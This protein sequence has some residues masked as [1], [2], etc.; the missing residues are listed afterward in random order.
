MPLKQNKGGLSILQTIILAIF[1]VV[2]LSN[3]FQVDFQAEL[4]N[5]KVQGTISN[6][7]G[8]II[9]FWENHL[10]NPVTYL[11]LA[12]LDNM[13]RIH[14]GQPTDFDLSAPYVPAP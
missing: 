10:K 3:Y 11:W 4:Q 7:K 9:G 12:F 8:G 13:Q 5:E 6:V 2:I 1:I 14:D